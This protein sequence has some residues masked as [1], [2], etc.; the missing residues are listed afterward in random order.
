VEFESQREKLAERAEERE[1]ERA[2]QQTKLDA[3]LKKQVEEEENSANSS[4]EL[5]E[6][7]TEIKGITE[8]RDNASFKRKEL[9]DTFYA[10][11]NEVAQIDQHLRGLSDITKARI[12]KLRQNNPP[13]YNVFEWVQKNKSKFKAPVF[14]PLVRNLDPRIPRLTIIWPCLYLADA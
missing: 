5:A 9:D 10:N 14:G 6:L 12:S 2:L 4:S 1:K 7:T 11:K 8:Q 3:A 13:V